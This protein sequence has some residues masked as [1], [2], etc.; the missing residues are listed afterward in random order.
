MRLYLIAT[1]IASSLLLEGCNGYPPPIQSSQ[2]DNTQWRAT[3]PYNPDNYLQF[4]L[5]TKGDKLALYGKGGCHQIAAVMRID[6]TRLYPATSV[7]DKNSGKCKGIKEKM[8]Q[9]YVNAINNGLIYDAGNLY[10]SDGRIAFYR[11][12]VN[13]AP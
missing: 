2:L 13:D 12:T 9:S 6:G 1:A 10:T 11:Q 4:T 7:Y 8:I 3:S 5:R